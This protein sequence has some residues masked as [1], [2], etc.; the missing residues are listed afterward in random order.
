[1]PSQARRAFDQSCEDIDRLLEI[2]SD[3]GGDSPGRRRRLEVL[4]KSAI[5]L[6]TALWEAYCEDIAAEGLGHLVAGAQSADSLP[7]DLR[8]QVAKELERDPHELASWKLAGDG[9]REVLSTRLDDLRDE[10][11]RRL[12][13]PKTFQIDDLFAKALGIPKASS[14]WYWPSMSAQQAATK[15]DHYVGLR[16]AIAHRGAA[17]ISV[18]RTDVTDYYKHVKRLVAKTGGKVNGVVRQ[19]TGEGFL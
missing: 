13:T 15:L 17:S 10:R 12:N 11:N 7:T 18:R 2:H 9:W 4:N 19:A 14:S 3:L 1:M 5:V 16:G 8:K 6:I